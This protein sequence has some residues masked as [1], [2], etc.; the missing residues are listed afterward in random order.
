RLR[1]AI[2]GLWAEW[3]AM[4]TNTA[5]GATR[6]SLI[7]FYIRQAERYG[8]LKARDVRVSVSQRSAAEECQIS[9]ASVAKHL[10]ALEEG[11]SLYR[12]RAEHDKPAAV[13]LRGGRAESNQGEGRRSQ[14]RESL[15]TEQGEIVSSTGFASHGDY[16]VRAGQE[17]A[18]YAGSYHGDY[19]V[20]GVRGVRAQVP[21]MRWSRAV[22][23][24]RI[25]Q[26][27]GLRVYEIEPLLRHGKKRQH[28]VEYIAESGGTVSV[29]ELMERFAGASTRPRDFKARTLGPLAD[30]PKI[31]AIEGEFV[32]L[33]DDWQ[34]ALDNARTVVWEQKD[35]DRQRVRHELQRAAFHG[36][37]D[38]PTD[39]SPTYADLDASREER[40]LRRQEAEQSRS[41]LAAAMREYLLQNPHDAEQPAN[42]ITTT[43]WAYSW[44]E[45][46]PSPAESKAALEELGGADRV[47]QEMR[48]AS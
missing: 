8:E 38:H 3:A 31:I 4:P 9:Q 32:T 45:S 25:D 47:L 12:L 44:I 24:W 14:E 6:K 11:A 40:E 21:E 28:I 35:S 20:R 19:S 13:V 39:P 2:D 29:P 33:T 22:I 17:A 26:P 36:R 41:D 34:Q 15:S 10:A 1:A 5:V 42:W 48:D 37:H 7:R 43:M 46:N 18:S 23:S 30:D 16:S 27:S